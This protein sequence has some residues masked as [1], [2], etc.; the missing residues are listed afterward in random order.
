MVD[1]EPRHDSRPNQLWWRNLP[2]PWLAF[3]SLTFIIGAAYLAYV[4]AAE[5]TVL[6]VATVAAATYCFVVGVL[7]WSKSRFAL[8]AYI[9]AGLAFISWAV[10]RAISSGMTTNRIGILIG[11]L[12]IVLSYSSLSEILDEQNP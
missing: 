9:V 7:L 2:S 4:A 10:F 6:R 12:L 11:G 3:Y 8:K 1:E 5:D